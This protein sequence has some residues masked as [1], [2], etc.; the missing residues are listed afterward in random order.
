MSIYLIV[1]CNRKN[2]FFLLHV[3]TGS[4]ALR[5]V[6]RC[7]VDDY[8]QGE[9]IKTSHEV[10]QVIHETLAVFLC[11][12]LATYISQGAPSLL[13]VTLKPIPT[14]DEWDE[15]ISNVLAQDAEEH[16]FKMVA[17]C[18]ELY[19]FGYK[20]ESHKG[21]LQQL[22]LSMLWQCA[23]DLVSEPLYFHIDSKTADVG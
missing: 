11:S 20:K 1:S 16:V 10:P 15:L 3:S 8:G 13:P 9:E 5:E 4:W 2:D 23:Q 12:L 22:K 18:K 21:D 17:I 6:L 14:K 7:L 19:D